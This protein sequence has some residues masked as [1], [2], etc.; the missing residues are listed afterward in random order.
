MPTIS[1]ARVSWRGVEFGRRA[2]LKIACILALAC[3][4]GRRGK[5]SDQP[6][7]AADVE[8]EAKEATDACSLSALPLR[9][10]APARLVAI[11][12]LHGDLPATKDAL[13]AAGAIDETGAWTGGELV[14]VQTGDILDRGDDEVE[15]Y[16]YL[17]SLAGQ[18][19]KAGGAIVLLNG[20]HEFMNARGDMSYVTAGGFADFAEPGDVG[21]GA[22]RRRANFAPGGA[23][24]RRL[25]AFNVVAIV[26]DTVF[27]HG[28]IE[29][30]YAKRDLG[31]LNR[32]ARCWLS[33]QS[34]APP[35]FL[36]DDGPVW[37]RRFSSD[38]P[39]CASLAVALASLGVKRMVVGH[40]TQSSGITKACDGTIW[41]IDV[42]LS[43]HYGGPIE[44]LELRDGTAKVL[45]GTRSP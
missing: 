17:E 2:L 22:G 13:R 10:P 27:A 39:D 18:A 14:V 12:D 32:E 23:F 24:A 4:D 6:S 42:G 43:R 35:S 21:S 8:L 7:P 30:S 31:A 36:G 29:P 33:G 34:K 3:S 20:N 45:E 28:G 38:P 25:A 15:I 41:R 9:R 37:S 44:V 1:A 5:V 26:G 19:D 16:A 11:G 40:T